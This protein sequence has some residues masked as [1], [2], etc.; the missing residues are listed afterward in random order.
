[1]FSM[2]RGDSLSKLKPSSLWP[3][4]TRPPST[5]T[6]VSSPGSHIGVGRVTYTGSIELH[7]STC[8]MSMSSS[9]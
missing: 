3:I 5:C 9:S 1:M 4:S 6:I 8:L 7:D 2:W